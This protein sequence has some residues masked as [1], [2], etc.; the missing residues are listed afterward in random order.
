MEG[1]GDAAINARGRI[2]YRRR[3]KNTSRKAG[4]V[5][6]FVRT[7]GGGYDYM[8]VLDADSV[9]SGK[10]LVT[11]ARLL[12]ANPQV[13]LIPDAAEPGRPRHAVR[14]PAAV[15]GA[16]EFADA[17]ERPRV[18]AAQRKQLLGAQRHHACAR[19]R[20]PLRA[21]APAGQRSRSAARS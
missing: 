15:R 1:A 10:A 17:L 20:Q 19:V 13:G 6:D 11:L 5:A 3:E 4:N 21:A 14:P 2:F 7:W 9:M 18:L 8:V 16:P 12:D